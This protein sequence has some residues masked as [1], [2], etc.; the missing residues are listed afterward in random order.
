MNVC[1]YV[2]MYV[3]MS[4]CLY[5]CMSVCLYVFMY[6]CMYACM[7]VCICVCV[8]VCMCVCV[9]VYMCM[10]NYMCICVNVDVFVN[11]NH[12]PT[13]FQQRPPAADSR[14]VALVSFCESTSSSP[15]P[16]LLGLSS[17]PPQ[18]IC[19]SPLCAASGSLSIL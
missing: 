9:Y 16:W 17:K 6:V 10:C 14:Q 1:I 19:L 7:H 3:C 5:A 8:Y 4:V 15:L 13:H 12:C 11:I 18:S 2:C